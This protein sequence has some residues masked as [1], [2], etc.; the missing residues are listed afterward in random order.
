MRSIG[1]GLQVLGL[2]FPPLA[3]VLQL[4]EAISL[5]QMLVILASSVCLFLI[6]RLLEGYA[7]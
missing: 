1:R 2:A 6:G 4:A 5:G 3:M 7:R